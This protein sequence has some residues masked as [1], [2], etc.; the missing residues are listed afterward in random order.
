MSTTVEIFFEDTQQTITTA[1]GRN[2]TEICDDYDTPVFFGC[3]A[4]SC[5][6][7]MI[8]VTRGMEFLSPVTHEE[9]VL[10]DILAEG[11]KKAR[12]AC[13]CIVK[14]SIAVK[15]LAPT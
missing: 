8:E 3:R 12:L 9:E 4:A 13:Q 10:L 5:A 7:C 1:A 15:V 11:N 2:F 14:G 6:T